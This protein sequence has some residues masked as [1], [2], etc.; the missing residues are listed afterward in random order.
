MLVV[1]GRTLFEPHNFPEGC[2]QRVG[3]VAFYDDSLQPLK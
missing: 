1:A 2:C 3:V